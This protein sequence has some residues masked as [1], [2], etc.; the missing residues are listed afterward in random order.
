MP[1][2]SFGFA[3]LIALLSSNLARTSTHIPNSVYGL[4]N[5]QSLLR[6]SL[7]CILSSLT[8]YLPKA[9]VESWCSSTWFTPSGPSP[10]QWSWAG[11]RMLPS[12]SSC[13]RKAVWIWDRSS[14]FLGALHNAAKQWCQ[15]L[16]SEVDPF[17]VRTGSDLTGNLFVKWIVQGWSWLQLD[18]FSSYLAG[19][20][21]CL[22]KKEKS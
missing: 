4:I 9:L 20:V 6:L 11:L 7:P 1:L 15:P 2:P 19:L 13:P 8:W 22:L 10:E 3:K 16:F 5:L 12:W 18:L 21:L 14:G 17:S